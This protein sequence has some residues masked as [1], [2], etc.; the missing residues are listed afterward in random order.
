MKLGQILFLLPLKIG[1]QCI[2]C[3]KHLYYLILNCT[4]RQKSDGGRT[5][6]NAVILR[7]NTGSDSL[8]DIIISLESNLHP[9]E[10]DH[11][12]LKTNEVFYYFSGVQALCLHTEPG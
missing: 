4:T 5:S 2:Y 3:N 6:D 12:T 9:A 1:L 11:Y 7:D 8:I 10:E